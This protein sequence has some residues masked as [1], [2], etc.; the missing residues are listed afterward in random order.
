M[1]GVCSL[2]Q[3]NRIL[4]GYLNTAV[5]FMCRS[6]FLLC[7]SFL[8]VL[9]VLA[10]LLLMRVHASVSNIV[11]FISYTYRNPHTSSLL[12]N[13]P[14]SSADGNLGER[15]EEW[16]VAQ[17]TIIL[18]IALGNIPVVGEL[19]MLL[20][21]PGL[22]LGGAALAVAGVTGLGQSLSP[23]PA[24]VKDNELMTDGVY[25]LVRHPTYA[26]EREGMGSL[27]YEGGT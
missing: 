27:W 12:V 10:L 11:L 13:I 24:P 19:V 16:A 9:S 18:F 23:W 17:L 15:G 21:G 14:C 22:M 6:P 2:Q 26:G 8:F 20:V 7:C 3:Y 1:L 25:G 5:V 4:V